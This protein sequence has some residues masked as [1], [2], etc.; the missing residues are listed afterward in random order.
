M[1]KIQWAY[2]GINTH[3]TM[4]NHAT[5]NNKLKYNICSVH[6][7]VLLTSSHREYYIFSG[8]PCRI[9]FSENSES[10]DNQINTFLIDISRIKWL[11]FCYSRLSSAQLDHWQAPKQRPS[12]DQ[13]PVKQ[14]AYLT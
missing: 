1:M 6:R 2:H 12:I 4:F 8:P 10:P 7:L 11:V 13:R 9:N 5:Q 3:E 14:T